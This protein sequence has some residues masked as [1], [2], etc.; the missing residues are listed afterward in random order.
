MEPTRAISAIDIDDPNL[1]QL[2]RGALQE[3]ELQLNVG[4]HLDKKASQQ[5]RS[6]SPFLPAQ[7]EWKQQ[8]QCSRAEEKQGCNNLSIA[9]SHH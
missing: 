5:R 4:V 8:S 3:K 9:H 1:G 2:K 6:C 7:K